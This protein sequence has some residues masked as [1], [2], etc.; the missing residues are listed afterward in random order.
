MNKKYFDFL[1]QTNYAM[2]FTPAAQTKEYLNDSIMA[3]NAIKEAIDGKTNVFCDEL[4]LLLKTQ[5]DNHLTEIPYGTKLWHGQFRYISNNLDERIADADRRCAPKWYKT[6]FYTIS[7]V[8][9]SKTYD[10]T[11]SQSC[12][13]SET[14]K[15][16]IPFQIVDLR[17]E[18]KDNETLFAAL[19][20][21]IGQLQYN[22]II[23]T[24]NVDFVMKLIEE[25]GYAGV[26][27]KSAGTK[28]DVYV[29]FNPLKTICSINR[30]IILSSDYGK[31][32]K[33]N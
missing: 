26:V 2:L 19:K 28:E 16:F 27:Y 15:V 5:L 23:P 24:T 7:L 10:Y 8:N 25:L 32:F 11:K 4:R 14:V 9:I 1:E 29:I 22:S 30:E 21:T 3:M 33:T 13:A 18:A 12:L 31:F 6:K 17:E 20:V